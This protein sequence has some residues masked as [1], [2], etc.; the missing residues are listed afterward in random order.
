MRLA[1][2]AVVLLALLWSPALAADPPDFVTV[3]SFNVLHG[4]PWSGFGGDGHRLERRLAMVADELAG[5]RADV[6][7]LQEASVTRRSGN[8][9]ERLARRLGLHHVYAPATSHVFGDGLLSRLVVGALGFHE[10][11]AIL[12][13]FPIVARQVHALPRCQG[14]LDPRVVLR[15]RLDTPWGLV[16]VFSTHTSR[17]ACQ[18]RRVAEL[19]GQHRNGLPSILMGDFNHVETSAAIRA[20]TDEAGFIDTYRRA[21]PDARGATVWQ[22]IDGPVATAS[23]RIDYVFLIPGVEITGRVRGSRVILDTP[24]RLPEGSLLWP[25]DHHGVLTELELRDPTAPDR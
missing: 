23:R 3:V 1:A 15:A 22:R 11:P 10:G 24:H 5:L 25:S 16:D 9:S 6:I 19:A 13:R 7:A 2:T 20:L 17:D 21:N 14:A 18:V 8:V 4:G 12:S